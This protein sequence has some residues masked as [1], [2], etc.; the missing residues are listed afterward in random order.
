MI[1]HAQR[2]V[3]CCRALPPLAEGG[4]RGARGAWVPDPGWRWLRASLPEG[5]ALV[6]ALELEGEEV[7]VVALA[8]ACADATAGFVLRYLPVT[9]PPRYE[10]EHY[11]AAGPVGEGW[12]AIYAR[13][14]A[15][16]AAAVAAEEERQ[17]Q[18][19][20]TRAAWRPDP[21]ADDW[22]DVLAVLDR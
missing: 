3:V 2:T 11:G 18:R 14:D 22:G 9:A 13:A 19:A 5:A 15:Y 7:A 12:G 1:R 20:A 16:V 21:E 6:Q 17:H 8:R 10:V 4:L